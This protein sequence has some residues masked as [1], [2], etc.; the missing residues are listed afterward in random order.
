MADGVRVG[1]DL[2]AFALDDD[3][4]VTQE[5]AGFAVFRLITG[6]EDALQATAGTERIE[7]ARQG[8]DGGAQAEGVAQVDHPLQLRRPGAEGNEG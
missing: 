4:V 6:M 1:F 2:A 3:G 5:P 7:D 8:V